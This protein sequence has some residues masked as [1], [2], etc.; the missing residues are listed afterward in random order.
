MILVWFLLFGWYFGLIL[1][2]SSSLVICFVCFYL[3]LLAIVVVVALGCCLFCF[4]CLLFVCLCFCLNCV[5]GL[6]DLTIVNSC[7]LLRFDDDF[8]CWL[9][10]SLMMFYVVL[11]YCLWIWVVS[12][13]N[14]MCCIGLL[15]LVDF[16]LN[17]WFWG[18]YK[19]EGRGFVC[20]RLVFTFT[21]LGLLCWLCFVR[22]LNLW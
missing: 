12:D 13:L 2:C 15:V 8:F 5:C 9:C 21:L 1:L 19:T 16:W 7:L 14:C 20:L 22:L 18:W 17:W 11:C 3:N 6:V 4:G 10:F